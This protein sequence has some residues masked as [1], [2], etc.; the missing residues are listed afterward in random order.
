ME[1]FTTWDIQD[2]LK[3]ETQRRAFLRHVMK[4]HGGDPEYITLCL[5]E[6]AKARG[7]QE[8]MKDNA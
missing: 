3:T 7:I 6:I 8:A 2:G 5:A 1:T 4:E